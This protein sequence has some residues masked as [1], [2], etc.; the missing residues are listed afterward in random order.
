[1]QMIDTYLERWKLVTDG[2]PIVTRSATL[3]PVKWRNRQ[4][5]LKIAVEKEERDG[6]RL[7]AWWNGDGAA[8]VFAHEVDALLM[9]RADSCTS[10]EMLSRT[11]RDDEASN[12]ICQVVS[13]L[14]AQRSKPLPELTPLSLWFEGLNAA[15]KVQG[16]IFATT[17]ATANTLLSQPRDIVVLHGDIHHF[18]ILDFGQRG[19]LAIDPKGLIGERGFD[20]ANL[21]C[22]P[23]Q[24]TAGLMDRFL[25]R[26]DLVS[27]SAC[28]ERT[29]L[30]QWILAWSGLSAAW[31]VEDG[32]Q[33][34]LALAIAEMSSAVLNATQ[35]R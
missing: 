20:Y 31:H 21:F 34:T 28:I 18:N 25:Q 27:R 1:M 22:N 2:R 3:L 30:L 11:G 4:A 17:A 6:A 32:T 7:M 16:G 10:L 13:R 35:A 9:E 26:V 14:H 12:I 23:D 15:A 8:Q 33:P 29:R 19:W 5:M 24:E